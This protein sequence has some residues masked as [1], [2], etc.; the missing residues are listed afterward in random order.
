MLVI[1]DGLVQ[2]ATRCTQQ[3]GLGNPFRGAGP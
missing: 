3:P 2:L 1:Y